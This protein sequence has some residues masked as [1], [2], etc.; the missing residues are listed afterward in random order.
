MISDLYEF[1]SKISQREFC[2]TWMQGIEYMVWDAAKEGGTSGPSAHIDLSAEE[3]AFAM[4]L[5][6]DI[7]GWLFWEDSADEPQFITM[8]DWLRKIEPK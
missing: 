4:K 6:S 1:L 5:S 2:A 3:A 7:G 8:S